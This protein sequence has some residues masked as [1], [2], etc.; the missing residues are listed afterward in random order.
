VGEEDALLGVV[1]FFVLPVVPA[2]QL[3]WV[4]V[5]KRIAYYLL[6]PAGIVVIAAVFAMTYAFVSIAHPPC[7][8]P[9]F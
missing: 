3:G 4:V 7:N 5:Q 9:D 1:F 6:I 2:G 8:L